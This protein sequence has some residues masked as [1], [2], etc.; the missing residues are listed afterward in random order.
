MR[1]IFSNVR[2]EYEV[3][4]GARINAPPI[5]LSLMDKKLLG[6]VPFSYEG[7]VAMPP[8][9]RRPR[10]AP[11]VNG[12]WVGSRRSLRIRPRQTEMLVTRGLGSVVVLIVIGDC[13]PLHSHC[14]AR[15]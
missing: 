15:L 13:F 5:N 12:K 10:K 3:E 7:G 9:K 6:S 8:E 14:V 2:L 11:E 4:I 1:G